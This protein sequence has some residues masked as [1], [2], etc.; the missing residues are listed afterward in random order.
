MG[1]IAA[2]R[3][4]PDELCIIAQTKRQGLRVISSTYCGAT[5]NAG[6]GVEQVHTSAISCEMCKTMVKTTFGKAYDE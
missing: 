1:M 6:D 5:E 4:R 2:I 3:A